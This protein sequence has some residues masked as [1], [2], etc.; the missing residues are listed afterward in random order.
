MNDRGCS[1]VRVT[2]AHPQPGATVGQNWRGRSAQK[3][4]CRCCWRSSWETLQ[5][6]HL[7]R[8]LA[9]ATVSNAAP[10]PPAV[11]L[12]S[13]RIRTTSQGRGAI[14]QQ[15][16]VRVA[17]HTPPRNRPC[18]SGPIRVAFGA[19]PPPY[20]LNLFP[21]RN[22]RCDLARNGNVA[23]RCQFAVEIDGLHFSSATPLY[24]LGEQWASAL[25]RGPRYSTIHGPPT[26]SHSN[27]TSNS[28]AKNLNQ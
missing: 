20:D 26:P 11:R 15:F 22:L 23:V 1:A 25:V 14:D 18:R 28:R 6:N 12:M 21:R 5:S 9:P 8:I 27:E 19:A 13:I 3:R 16:V 10:L 17:G 4:R 24:H 7:N 2:S